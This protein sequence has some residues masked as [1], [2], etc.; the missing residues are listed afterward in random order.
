V[1]SVLERFTGGGKAAV[2]EATVPA[3]SANAKP[4]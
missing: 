1:K 4:N 3:P 2:P